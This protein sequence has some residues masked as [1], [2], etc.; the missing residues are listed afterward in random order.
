MRAVV[1]YDLPTE[2]G[3]TEYVHRVGRTARAG[4]GGEAWS[5]LA[6]SETLWAQWAQDKMEDGG[7]SGGNKGNVS[8]TPI[9]IDDV[10]RSGFG[11]KGQEYEDRATEVQLAFERWVL[12]EKEVSTCDTPILCQPRADWDEPF[13]F[14]RIQ[15]IRKLP[16]KHIYHT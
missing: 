10:L 15:R 14:F 4:K 11:G 2:G 7:K 3:V 16:A 5:I 8:L 13:F 1:Q 9:G 6:P 12:C